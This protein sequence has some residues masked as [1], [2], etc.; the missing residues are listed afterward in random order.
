MLTAG[1]SR[2]ERCY[3]SRA[4]AAFRGYEGPDGRP[5]R[6]YD[7]LGRS[8]GIDGGPEAYLVEYPAGRVTRAHFHPVDQFQVFFGTP[9][10]HYQRHPIP[11]VMVHYS[12]AF[13]TYGPFGSDDEGM[14]F[15]TLRPRASRFTAYMP[16]D[17]D[18]LR[19]RGRHRGHFQF[20]AAIEPRGPV[21][22]V[23]TEHVLS[24]AS[25]GPTIA[26]VRAGAG[27]RVEIGG[28]PDAARYVCVLAGTATA[29][30]GDVLEPLGLGWS[31]PAEAEVL[32]A[33][34]DGCD[35]LALGFPSRP[36][37]DAA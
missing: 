20:H 29:G 5:S 6:V 23:V 22:G 13:T 21:A 15:F 32:V 37:E 36:V 3:R 16:E 24:T 35:L 12:D 7:Y 1:G 25:G 30:T 27:A 18:R 26:R 34:D 8:S 10:S 17:R 14:R 11:A 33:G 4:S 28:A 31:E 2:A 9:G 19:A